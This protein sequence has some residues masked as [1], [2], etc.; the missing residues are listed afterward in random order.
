MEGVSTNGGFN[1]FG[2]ESEGVLPQ[3]GYRLIA[4]DSRHHESIGSPK[5]GPARVRCDSSG[6]RVVVIGPTRI[7]DQ[8]EHRRIPRWDG[9]NRSEERRVG[10]ECRS[11]WS[12]Y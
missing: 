7:V 6:E 2:R 10:K 3:L 8:R 12:P 5:S 1:A 9:R 11:R 4:M